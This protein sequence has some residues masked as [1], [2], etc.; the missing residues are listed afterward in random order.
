MQKVCQDIVSFGSIKTPLGIVKAIVEQEKYATLDQRP[1]SELL[2]LKVKGCLSGY[3]SYRG[4]HQ[5]STGSSLSCVTFKPS[6][7]TQAT[8]R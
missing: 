7:T 8:D 5:Q 6:N 2:L 1:P 3:T 4:A